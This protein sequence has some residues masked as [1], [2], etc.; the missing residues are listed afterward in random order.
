VPD[1]VGIAVPLIDGVTVL[2]AEWLGVPLADDVTVLV[3][4]EVVE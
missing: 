2:V 4:D 1:A 3:T